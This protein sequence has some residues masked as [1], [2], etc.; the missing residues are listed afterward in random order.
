MEKLTSANYKVIKLFNN[1]VVL[2]SQYDKEKIL[3]GK[4][5]GFGKHAG[6]IIPLTTKIDKVFTLE[7]VNNL[8]TFKQLVNTVDKEL[9]GLCEEIIYMIS[10]EVPEELDEKVHISV[11]DH[12]VTALK[13]LKNNEEIQNPFLVE[14]ETL[15]PK[16]FE[17]ASKVVDMLQDRTKVV[18]P[19]GEIGFIA[20]HIHSARNKGKLSNTIKYAFLSNSIIEL[21]ENNLNIK[22][23]KKSL[24]Y[25]RFL[26]HI[27][28]AI[29]RILNN[30]KIK[31]ELLGAIKEKYPSSYK[32]AEKV[33]MLIESELHLKVVE[34]ETAFIA[35]HIERFKIALEN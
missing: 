19:N 11:T 2:V 4:G 9:I 24:D 30:H 33:V 17:I 27:R 13:R 5:L 15:Y 1:N 21:I 16:E 26:T 35:T 25:A 31:N 18:I 7:D 10:Q 20:L 28:F 29:E 14:I 3:F 12:I 22:I 34:D 6:D 32:L 8:N 23:N